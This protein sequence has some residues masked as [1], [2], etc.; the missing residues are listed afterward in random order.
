MATPFS[1]ITRSAM[2][3]YSATWPNLRGGV[4][5]PSG[6]GVVVAQMP[7]FLLLKDT[8]GDD[9]ADVRETILTGWGTRDTH[10]GPNNL[11]YGFDNWLWGVVGYSGF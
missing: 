7:D 10:A 3:L 6:I 5:S 11:Q 8:T 1:F 2:A 9:R 4:S